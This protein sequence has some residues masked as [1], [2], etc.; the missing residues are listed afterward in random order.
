MRLLMLWLGMTLGFVRARNEESSQ[1]K[2]VSV[3]CHVCPSVTI[4]E[5]TAE[6]TFVEFSFSA[7]LPHISARTAH[8]NEAVRLRAH[9]EL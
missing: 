7:V 5:E 6:Q 2:N 3:L 8:E 9:L 1:K 4:R